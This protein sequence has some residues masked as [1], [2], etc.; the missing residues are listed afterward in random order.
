[1]NNYT[2][3]ELIAQRDFRK[4]EEIYKTPYYHRKYVEEIYAAADVHL[5]SSKLSGISQNGYLHYALKHRDYESIRFLHDRGAD[6]HHQNGYGNLVTHFLAENP[7]ASEAEAS[8]FSALLHFVL[9]QGVSATRPNN[10]NTP[11]FM[12][13]VEHGNLCFI[14]ELIAHRIPLTARDHDGNTILHCLANHARQWEPKPHADGERQRQR[15]A[16]YLDMAKH[17]MQSGL[18]H[19]Q[20]NNKGINAAE[21]ASELNDGTLSLILNDDYN[22]NDPQFSLKLAARGNTLHQAVKKLA[23]EEDNPIYLNTIKALFQLGYDSEA[24]EGGQTPLAVACRT[25]CPTAVELLLA[26]GAD[27]NFRIGENDRTALF[28]LTYR[29]YPDRPPQQQKLD[30]VLELLFKA[31]LDVNAAVDGDGNGPLAMAC[32]NTTSSSSCNI[33]HQIV[34]A[35]LNHGAQV[36]ARNNKGETPL[37]LFLVHC[38]DDRD[39]TLQ[40]LLEQGADATLKDVNGETALMKISRHR[41]SSLAYALVQALSQAED[42]ALDATNNNGETALDIAISKNNDMLAQ[43]LVERG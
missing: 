27:P 43:W 23:E 11:P 31:D 37:M 17:L 33:R 8:R 9:E 2:R 21:I 28:W 4:L 35:L 41:N 24:V 5:Y 22:P 40:T 10:Q 7:P 38:Q 12:V 34:A 20:T 3:E 30:R 18:D 29:H 26:N 25:L 14:Q 13:A 16:N 42:L 19:E 36:N 1:M 32:I 15:F 39:S 6:I